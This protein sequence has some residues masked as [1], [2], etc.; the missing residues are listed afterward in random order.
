MLAAIFNAMGTSV[1]KSTIAKTPNLLLLLTWFI[2][3]PAMG[4][5]ESDADPRMFG[6]KIPKG[7]V[8]WLKGNSNAV[9]NSSGGKLIA[10]PHVKVGDNVIMIMPDG[11]LEPVNKS[12]ITDWTNDK[13]KWKTPED[14][15]D[16]VLKDPRLRGM[17][18][19]RSPKTSICLQLLRKNG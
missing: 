17:R 1:A 4:Q 9:I 15:V 2:A 12:Q 5:A 18:T 6:F 10:K 14:M 7:K 3:S 16:I 13:V 8:T 19:P 11:K